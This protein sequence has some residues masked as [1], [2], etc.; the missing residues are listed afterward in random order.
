[1]KWAKLTGIVAV[2]LLVSGLSAGS[3][4]QAGGGGGESVFSF[5]VSWGEY[6][7]FTGKY[8]IRSM[9]TMTPEGDMDIYPYFAN[10]HE[11]GGGRYF[12]Y[13]TWAEQVWLS[14]P[15][16]LYYVNLIQISHPDRNRSFVRSWAD[17][18]VCRP[19]PEFRF[20]QLGDKTTVSATN[21]TQ[22]MLTLVF[23]EQ[24]ITFYPG[25]SWSFKTLDKSG[26]VELL[27]S[28]GTTCGGISWQDDTQVVS[29]YKLYFPVV[30]KE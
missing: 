29:T 18:N 21:T 7:Q 2:I 28:S 13:D 27:T 8:Q 25:E 17:S 30:R 22:V 20:D 5:L 14:D 23:R 10:L 15:Y 3:T 19:G 6:N 4:V 12:L 16:S 11:S 24:R 9:E 1:M 26:Q